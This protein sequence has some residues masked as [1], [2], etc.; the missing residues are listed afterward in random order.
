MAAKTATNVAVHSM[1]DMTLHIAY[2]SDLDPADIW[3]S[4]IPNIVTAW[5]NKRDGEANGSGA[6]V[7]VG[8]T[9]S[10][11]TLSFSCQANSQV[12]VFVLILNFL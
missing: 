7:A 3:N 8:W 6:G 2:I 9:Q 11:G 5:A 4:S 1:G 10:N 12:D